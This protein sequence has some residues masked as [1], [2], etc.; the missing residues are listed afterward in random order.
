MKI[1]VIEGNEERLGRISELAEGL[2]DGLSIHLFDDG[3]DAAGYLKYKEDSLKKRIRITTF[4]NFS[5][6]ADGK[7]VQFRYSKSQELFAIL[8]DAKGTE[9]SP[10]GIRDMLWQDSEPGNKHASYLS[11]LKKDMVR[12]LQR[13]GAEDIIRQD[14]KGLALQKDRLDCDLFDY[15]E[16]SEGCPEFKGKYMEQYSWAEFTV[17][18]LTAIERKR[19]SAESDGQA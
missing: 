11:I 15:L 2:G 3:N 4:G 8:V 17:G 18:E 16:G 10:D 12:T 13:Y 1:L 9:V 14:E 19:K 6:F 7:N 5:V